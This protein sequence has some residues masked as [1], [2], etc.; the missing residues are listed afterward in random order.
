MKEKNIILLKGT[1]GNNKLCGSSPEIIKLGNKFISNAGMVTVP[2]GTY[3][4][5]AHYYATL[6][7]SGGGGTHYYLVKSINNKDEIIQDFGTCG[8][9]N[10]GYGG[11]TIPYI[12]TTTIETTIYIKAQPNRTDITG[13][14]YFEIKD[15]GN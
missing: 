15:L 8:S 14:Q 9:D 6:R 2:A 12:Y 3:M 13:Y 4:I 1:Y 7:N 11:G 5:K 10:Y